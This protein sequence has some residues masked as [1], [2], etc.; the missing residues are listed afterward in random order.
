MDPRNLWPHSPES[1]SSASSE[2]K[3]GFASLNGIDL[4]I[5][6]YAGRV[7][8]TAPYRPFRK[9]PWPTQSPGLLKAQVLFDL[10]SF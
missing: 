10:S 1:L 2:G 4:S 3:L 5:L 6:D 8:R 9:T 7:P